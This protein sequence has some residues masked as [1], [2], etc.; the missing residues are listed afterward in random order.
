MI[1]EVSNQLAAK[2]AEARGVTRSRGRLCIHKI[3]G[4][5]CGSSCLGL[6][7][8]GADHVSVWNKDG[9]P[10]FYVSQP[11]SMGTEVV[12]ENIEFCREHGLDIDISAWPSWHFPGSVL[13][14]T[15]RK[16]TG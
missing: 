2:W 10:Y 12:A 5:R 15:Y 6:Y 8:P 3:S 1:K 13:F 16:K 4:E 7:P 9:K 14:I 11:Y